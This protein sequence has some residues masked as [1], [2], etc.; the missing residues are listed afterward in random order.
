MASRKKSSPSGGIPARIGS[1]IAAGLRRLWSG[2]ALAT[3]TLVRRIGR[4]AAGLDPQH[5]RDGLGLFL[6]AMAAVVAAF[7]G[8]G[9]S[10]SASS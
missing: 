5:R 4:E 1:G 10:G 3:G 8:S 9:A 2:I 7:V 6:I